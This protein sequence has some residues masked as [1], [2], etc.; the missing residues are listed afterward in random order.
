MKYTAI[1]EDWTVE[2]ETNSK[3]EIDN[4]I[5]QHP[6]IFQVV[7]RKSNNHPFHVYYNGPDNLK[8]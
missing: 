8:Y 2:M 4:F 3:T 1:N 5:E 6:N 7:Y